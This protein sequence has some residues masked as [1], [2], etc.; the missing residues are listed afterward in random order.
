MSLAIE[1]FPPAMT[2]LNLERWQSNFQPGAKQELH[3][4]DTV[5]L[6]KTSRGQAHFY[7]KSRWIST[8]KKSYFCAKNLDR[9]TTKSSEFEARDGAPKLAISK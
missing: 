8:F 7:Q 5:S 2:S 1:P 6:A 3:R 4:M 9:D